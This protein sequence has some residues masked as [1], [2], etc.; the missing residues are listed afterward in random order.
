MSIISS[1]KNT[2][3]NLFVPR[4]GLYD[5]SKILI[6][7]NDGNGD[8]RINLAGLRDG[9]QVPPGGITDRG[10]IAADNL[11]NKDGYASVKEVRAY[12]KPYDASGDS[13]VEGVE[14]LTLLDDL[15]ATMPTSAAVQATTGMAQVA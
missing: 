8:G 2:F 5:Q 12:L 13:R 7:Q 10:F 9:A 15:T 11:G 6:G 1:I 14:L 4:D 3:E